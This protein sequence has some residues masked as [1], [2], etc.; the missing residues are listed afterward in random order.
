LNH[1][2]GKRW[3]YDRWF[4]KERDG[5]MMKL[6]KNI[7]GAFPSL[8]GAKRFAGRISTISKNS[9]NVFRET[10]SAWEGKRY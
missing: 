1:G 3:Q 8:E 4:L 10:G 7:S 6:E 2:R 5:R 9:G